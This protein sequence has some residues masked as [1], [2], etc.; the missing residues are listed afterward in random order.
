MRIRLV[1]I[2]VLFF[3]WCIAKLPKNR[4]RRPMNCSEAYPSIIVTRTQY[5]RTEAWISSCFV[6]EIKG[7]RGLS[8]NVFRASV[9][10]IRLFIERVQKEQAILTSTLLS[11]MR[12]MYIPSFPSTF[13]WFLFSSTFS[14]KM[15]FRQHCSHCDHEAWNLRSLEEFG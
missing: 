2:H 13:H 11:R 14:H 15:R 12:G 10:F 5:W 3:R 7:Y 8:S 6:I 9:A 1:A 4:V